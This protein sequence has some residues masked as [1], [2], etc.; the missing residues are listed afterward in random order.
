[1]AR[2]PRAF[3]GSFLK[4]RSSPHATAFATQLERTLA[5]LDTAQYEAVEVI[6]PVVIPGSGIGGPPVIRLV[7][8]GEPP[9]EELTFEQPIARIARYEA[10]QIDE[11]RTYV[12]DGSR[13]DVVRYVEREL[14]DQ[15][16]DRDPET[17]ADLL[18]SSLEG[19]A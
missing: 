19:E 1:M 12:E 14:A 10:E 18:I 6:Q 11:L 3:D 5:E 9:A 15:I 16:G 7:E 4:R 2:K 17:V 13:D 8:P